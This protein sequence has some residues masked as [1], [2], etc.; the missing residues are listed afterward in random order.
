MESKDTSTTRLAFLLAILLIQCKSVPGCGRNLSWLVQVSGQTS[1]LS[2]KSQTS[3][4][5]P[6]LANA[7]PGEVGSVGNELVQLQGS[8]LGLADSS[9][10]PV[11]TSVEIIYQNSSMKLTWIHLEMRQRYHFPEL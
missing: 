11:R 2:K 4:A 1:L 8:N 3:Y 9:R 5:G 10:T 7:L 6:S